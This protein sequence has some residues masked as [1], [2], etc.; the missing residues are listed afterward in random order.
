MDWRDGVIPV[1]RR[2]DDPY[3]SLNDGLAETRHVFL[4]GNGLP[5]RLH[6]GFRIAELGFGTGLNMLAVLIAW[7]G[8]GR[9]GRISFTSF[10]AFPLSATDITRALAHFPEAAFVAEPFLTAWAQGCRTMALPG[11]DLT[12][13]EGD[14]RST[15]P[16]WQGQADAWFLD[17]FSPAKNPE[18]WSPE[19]MASVAAHT[20]PGGTF[21]TYTAA[22]HVRRALGDA[23]FAVTR[24][25]GHGRKRHMTTGRI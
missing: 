2:F 3:F 18:L 6:D 19:L 7:A 24:Q 16:A 8:T 9:A 1:S 21:A 23:G 12:V 15:L 22:G 14:A 11:L 20:V 13:V 4:D 5:D 10:E 17:G 25:P